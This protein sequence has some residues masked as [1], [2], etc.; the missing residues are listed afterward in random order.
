MIAGMAAG[1]G[2]GTEA[3]QDPDQPHPPRGGR[4]DVGFDFLGFTIRQHPVGKYHTGKDTSGRPLGF[5]T[6]V[7]PGKAKVVAPPEAS[8]DSTAHRAAPE[9]ALI[10][11]LNPITRG[12][13]SYYRTAASKETF[14]E[15]TTCSG[16]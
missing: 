10:G 3:E 1:D 8:R 2:A 9:E 4:C 11:R 16:S 7:T 14:A 15:R 13:C 12:W 6:L 5:K